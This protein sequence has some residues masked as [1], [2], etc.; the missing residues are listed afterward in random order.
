MYELHSYDNCLTYFH[1]E[2]KQL[3]VLLGNV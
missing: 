2:K 3:T 1:F